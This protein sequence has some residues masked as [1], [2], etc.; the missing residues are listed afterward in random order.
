MNVLSSE[1][2]DKIYFGY[3]ES[4]K[5]T[6]EIEEFNMANEVV[7]YLS[8]YMFLSDELTKVI[9][10]NIEIKRFKK[11]TVLLKEGGQSKEC[12]LIFKGC[13]RSYLIK[14]G[15]ERTTE[16]YTEEQSVTP[17]CYGQKTPSEYYLECIEDTVAAIGS[18][19]LEIDVFS[20]FPQLESACRVMVEKMMANS[21]TLFSDFKITSPE[22]R[23]LKLL[24]DR[25]YLIQR[26]PQYQLASYL[27][28]KPESLS[29]IR[30]RLTKK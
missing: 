14:D 16:I 21:Q 17:V 12:Y 26:V 30:K 18:Y 22:E 27:G 29:R 20:K 13:I 8:R 10:E 3:A 2:R 6:N 19:E 24:K 4:C 15:D 28:I 5:T 11:G 23:Y 9:E 7:E 25:P 1:R